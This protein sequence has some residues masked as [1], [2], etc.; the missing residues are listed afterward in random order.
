MP[1]TTRLADTR[2][3]T[4]D[5]AKSAFADLAQATLRREKRAAAIEVRIAALKARLADD[6]A[7]DDAAIAAAEARLTAYILANPGQFR[8]PRQVRTEFGR[9][10]LR[11]AT[12]VDVRDEPALIAAL[13]DAGHDD[14]LVTR[15][16]LVRDALRKHLEAGETLPGCTLATGDVA[17]Y[18]V[19]K[20]LIEQAREEA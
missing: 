4:L 3:L 19:D 11:D 8:R 6:N 15:R 13:L 9:F 20:A 17:T 12:R 10:G 16:A 7:P 2:A 5:D 14:C 18:T 1:T